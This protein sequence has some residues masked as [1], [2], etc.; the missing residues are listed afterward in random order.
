MCWNDFEGLFQLRDHSLTIIVTMTMEISSFILSY[1][2]AGGLSIMNQNC[3]LG[4]LT[5]STPVL[6]GVGKYHA[7]FLD[8]VRLSPEDGD[9]D[10]P[11]PGHTDHSGL[12]FSPGDKP[13]S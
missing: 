8:C 3:L 13:R 7:A 9:R 11:L 10:I 2:W 5:D 12:P 1:Q 6:I 4:N